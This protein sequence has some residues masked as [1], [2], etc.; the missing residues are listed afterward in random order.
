MIKDYEEK[1]H[2]KKHFNTEIV[3]YKANEITDNLS[4]IQKDFQENHVGYINYETLIDQKI[5][6]ICE[7]MFNSKKNKPHRFN[8]MFKFLTNSIILVEELLDIITTLNK[9]VCEKSDYYT[10]NDLIMNIYST[11]IKFKNN[12]QNINYFQKSEKNA[13]QLNDLFKLLSEYVN[14]KYYSEDDFNNCD[15]KYSNVQLTWSY[16][17]YILEIYKNEKIDEYDN[18]NDSSK[19]NISW[20][21]MKSIANFFGFNKSKE[22]VITQKEEKPIIDNVIIWNQKLIKYDYGEQKLITCN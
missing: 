13:N 1:K 11:I 7:N 10:N 20:D 14:S 15:L 12:C 5:I 19:K 16:I 18:C 21:F 4:L 2:C 3:L 8:D 9:L 22:L 6:F 17:K